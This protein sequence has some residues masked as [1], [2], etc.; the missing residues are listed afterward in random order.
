MLLL[1]KTVSLEQNIHGIL[2]LL[3]GALIES[4]ALVKAISLVHALLVEAISLIESVALLHALLVK[5]IAFIEALL[6]E[7]ISLLKFGSV[8]I[9]WLL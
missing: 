2:Q 6:V 4:V 9:F 3:K 1:V 5:T 8:I 7:S